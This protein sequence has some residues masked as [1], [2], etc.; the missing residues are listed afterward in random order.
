MKTYWKAPALCLHIGMAA[1]VTIQLLLSLVM[2]HPRHGSHF[3]LNTFGHMAFTFHVW[4]GMLALCII[5]LHWL[6]SLS[7]KQ[8]I[9]S[10]KH[11]FPYSPTG[12][13]AVM[14]DIKN[15]TKCKIPEEG[16]RQ[17]LPGLIHGFGFLLVTAMVITGCIV[18]IR[19]ISG[20]AFSPLD[21]TAI[22]IHSFLATFVWIYWF[23]HV[24]TAILHWLQEYSSRRKAC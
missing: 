1:T 16:S 15:L 24:L 9:A 2:H 6:W 8:S 11:L 5:V 12:I 23:G 7:D 19:F 21:S 13:K 14:F 20:G 17:G 10:F 18:F 4:C 3:Q 22:N